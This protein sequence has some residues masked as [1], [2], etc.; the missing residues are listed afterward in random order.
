MLLGACAFDQPP[1]KTGAAGDATLLTR[2]GAALSGTRAPSSGNFIGA[3]R[4]ASGLAADVLSGIAS[5]RQQS[6]SREG[7]AVAR[8]EA[9]TELQLADGVDTDAEMQN[10][11]LIEQAYSANARVI[12]T[13]DDLIQQ[14]IGL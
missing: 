2:L 8:Q 4:S 1:G 9:L 7:F 11:L 3:A 14:L 13:I 5:A 6:E 10:L 12:R